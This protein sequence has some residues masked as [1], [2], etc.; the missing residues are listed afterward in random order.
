MSQKPQTKKPQTKKPRDKKPPNRA[1][2]NR[3]LAFY[4]LGLVGFMLLLSLV[5]AP[6]YR[7]FC[8][9]TGFGGTPITSN[10]EPILSPSERRV[11]INFN[12]DINPGLAWKIV[13]PPAV[14]DLP[15]GKA[16]EVFFTAENL[17]DQAITGVASFNVTPTKVSPYFDKVQCFC[18]DRQTLKP[19][20]KKTM[21]VRFFID[22]KILEDKTVAEV[23]AVTLHYSFFAEKK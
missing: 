6:L 3:R 7:A 2:S 17:T 5:S 9:V 23:S 20:Q 4:A 8:R 13:S 1:R 11:T 10:Q 21:G 15:I 12:H 18:F 16:A 19:H 14:V 22:P